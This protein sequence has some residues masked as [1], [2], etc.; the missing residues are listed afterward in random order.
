MK[1]FKHLSG[2]LS[3]SFIFE[4]IAQHGPAGYL[5]FF[6]TLEL[7]ADEFDI[8]N[9]GKNRFLIEKLTSKMQLSRQKTVRILKYIDRKARE[10]LKKDVGF[11][12][13]IDGG[14]I[15]LNCPK[16]KRLC[17]KFTRHELY[18]KLEFERKS[19]GSELEVNRK[20]EVEEDKEK[21][22]IKN[23]ERKKPV[24]YAGVELLDIEALRN[25]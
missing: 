4:L 3:D 20:Q 12:A 11:F 9:P 2:S 16:L 15:N 24:L 8:H 25:E 18:N 22:E 6:G 10:N 21:K 19:D 1:W 13:E 17:D 14:Y 5:V 7:M 23:K